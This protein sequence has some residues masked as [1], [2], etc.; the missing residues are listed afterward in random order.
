MKLVVNNTVKKAELRSDTIWN[1][2]QDIF[3]NC[4][5]AHRIDTKNSEYCE[6]A[7]M[8]FEL[9]SI[10]EYLPDEKLIEL[11]NNYRLIG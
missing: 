11:R 1:V 6:I 10:L 5:K 8:Q 9:E 3:N 7:G 4:I 2:A